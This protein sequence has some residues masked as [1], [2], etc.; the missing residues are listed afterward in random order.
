LFVAIILN[1]IDYI[2]DFLEKI[3][4]TSRSKREFSGV[5]RG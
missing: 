1:T 2:R 3:I 5:F 4:E